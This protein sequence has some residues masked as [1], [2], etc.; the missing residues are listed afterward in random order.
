MTQLPKTDPDFKALI[1][2]LHPHERIQLEQ[3]I[4]EKKKCYDAIILWEGTIIDGHNRFEICMK[5]GI[6]FEIKEIDL[7]SKEAAKAWILDNQLARRNLTDAARIEIE[8]LKS[9]MLREKAQKNQSYAGGDKKSEKSLSSLSSKPDIEPVDVRKTT[10]DN[11]GISEGKLN[12]Y[13]QI[14]DHGSPELQAQVISGNLKIGT[15]HRLLSKEILKQL[16]HANKLYKVIQDINPTNSTNPEIHQKLNRLSGQ[17][18]Q[19]IDKLT[20]RN[21]DETT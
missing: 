1:P 5:H 7:P 13:L 12:N 14:K 11:I 4:L 20:E 2:P 19:L 6:E 16:R 9:E 18:T 21:S 3:N 8:L 17:L 10:A 15:A